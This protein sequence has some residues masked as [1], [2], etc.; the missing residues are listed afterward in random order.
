M[1]NAY[2]QKPSR[3]QVI[4]LLLFIAQLALHSIFIVPP[5]D[6]IKKEILWVLLGF[7]YT[8]LIVTAH[9]YVYLTK[10][11]PVDRLITN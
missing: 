6:D 8:L 10:M 11:D 9:D 4:T 2:T 7:H 3:E 1:T 5:M